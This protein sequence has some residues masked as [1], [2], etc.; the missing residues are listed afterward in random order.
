MNARFVLSTIVA[1]CLTGAAGCTSDSRSAS[2]APTPSTPSPAPTPPPPPRALAVDLSGNDGL[3]G[4]CPQ[5][6]RH[7]RGATTRHVFHGRWR[8]W[9]RFRRTDSP[10]NDFDALH[11]LLQLLRRHVP[12]RATERLFG[13]CADA[14][15]LQIGEQPVD[16][17]AAMTCISDVR[18]LPPRRLPPP[19][20]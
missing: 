5:R 14:Q 2:S 15:P 6:Q 3:V 4:P 16:A 1:I 7:H 13:R 10:V 19:C 20:G 11:R 18:T 12:D 9:H 17:D 8:G